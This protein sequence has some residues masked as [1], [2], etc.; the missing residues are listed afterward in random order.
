MSVYYDGTYVYAQCIGNQLYGYSHPAT[1]GQQ[2]L[3][4]FSD[5]QCILSFRGAAE[6]WKEIEHCDDELVETF[7]R[8]NPQ[9]V[10]DF[11]PLEHPN[12]VVRHV[13]FL[14]YS[15]MDGCMF[16]D[17]VER[18]WQYL[19]GTTTYRVKG[20]GEILENELGELIYAVLVIHTLHS[21][22]TPHPSHYPDGDHVSQCL[23]HSHI[24]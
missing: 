11:K 4:Q 13:G 1:P 22:S 6:G 5:H 12:D 7:V 20:S 24:G 19:I 3:P 10:I 8:D 17:F 16:Y 2:L 23:V 14:K 9:T 18:K 15:L 21:I